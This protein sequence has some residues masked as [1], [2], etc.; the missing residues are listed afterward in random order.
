MQNLSARIK[1][2]T[3][4]ATGRR[5]DQAALGLK[6][7]GPQAPDGRRADLWP[8]ELPRTSNNVPTYRTKQADAGDVHASAGFG[9]R[10]QSPGGQ[11]SDH[12][13]KS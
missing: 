3:G 1:R 13:A 8:D 7:V 2:V 11:L 12:C 10:N 6:F 9:V 4:S 5:G